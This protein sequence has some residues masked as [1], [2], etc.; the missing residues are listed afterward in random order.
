MLL[1]SMFDQFSLNCLNIGISGLQV[2]CLILVSKTAFQHG[3]FEI[4]LT[5]LERNLSFRTIFLQLSPVMI[6]NKK[7]MLEFL[8]FPN[9]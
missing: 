1:E 2:I 7:K 8:P 5:V 3:H 6:K 9:I 4:I